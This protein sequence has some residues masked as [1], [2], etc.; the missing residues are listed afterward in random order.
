MQMHAHIKIIINFVACTY[1]GMLYGEGTQIQP[2]CSSR[3][4]CQNR[5]FQCEDQTCFA[6]GPTCY[7]FGDP[8][9]QTFDFKQYNFQG[10]CEYVLTTPCDD[11]QFTVIAGNVAKNT[12]SST[13]QVIRILVPGEGLHIVLESGNGGIV[14]INGNM[15]LKNGDGL[16]S[17]SGGV[18]V[19]R[20]GGHPHV[21][22]T[23]QGIRI[24]WDG[25]NRVEISISSSWQG[26]LCGLCGNYNND[27]TD[28]FIGLNGQ[29]FTNANQFVASWVVG[30][31]SSC[32]AL[33]QAPPCFGPARVTATAR[34]SN[35]LMSA[36]FAACHATVDPQQFI[37]RCIDDHCICDDAEKEDCFCNSL[38]TYASVCAAAGI[39]L[40]N[41]WRDIFCRKLNTDA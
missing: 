16:V 4:T 30:N 17:L 29:Q 3:C 10:D 41:T 38:A 37:N 8:H 1:M 14:T 12:F 19:V 15:H 21:L 32:G 35:A 11:D 40:P 6:D 22:L 2:N 26:R 39:L 24:F 28:D 31:T 9:Y 23:T 33:A 36:V 27:A 25:M 13:T 18:K 34:C 5:E 7:A 20:T